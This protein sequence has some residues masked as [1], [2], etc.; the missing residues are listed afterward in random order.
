MPILWILTDPSS[1]SSMAMA[2]LFLMVTIS[3]SR[4]ASRPPLQQ[5]MRSQVAR[6]SR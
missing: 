2:T 3:S 5:R 6:R 1:M 4:T